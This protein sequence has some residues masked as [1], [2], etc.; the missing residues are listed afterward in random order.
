MLPSRSDSYERLCHDS[1]IARFALDLTPVAEADDI[2]VVAAA[3]GPR[4]GFES[5]IVAIAGDE[6]GSVGE[7]EASMDERRDHGRSIARSPFRDCRQIP[8]TPR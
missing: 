8:S 3:L 1:G 6:I 2:A 5:G 4:G 7:R